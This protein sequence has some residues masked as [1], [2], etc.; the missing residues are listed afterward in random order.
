M[1]DETMLSESVTT[2]QVWEAFH[3]PLWQFIRKRVP[4]EQGA[5]DILQNVFLKV[6]T[7]INTIRQ[8]E[9]LPTWLYQVTRNAI[10]DY[11][12]D[13]QPTTSLDQSELQFAEELPEESV[14]FTVASW[15]PEMLADLPEVD[16]EALRL[17]NY[18]GMKQRELA[19]RLGLSFS[20]AKSRVQRAREKLKKGQSCL[21][22]L[23]VLSLERKT[24]PPRRH[25]LRP[26]GHE[27][28]CIMG[29][30]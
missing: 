4:D 5:E 8:R 21:A 25:L 11:Y 28:A 2:E 19:E 10:V 24:H 9:K 26:E 17:T 20:G 1:G 6:H 23:L 29:G 12:R 22:L 15:L 30:S 14:E 3:I 18:Q 13:L 7:H 27:E 16:R